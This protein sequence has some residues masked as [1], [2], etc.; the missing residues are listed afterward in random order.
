MILA[1]LNGREAAEIGAALADEFAPRAD[2]AGTRGSPQRGVS[3]SMEELLRRADV[4]VRPLQLNV[5]KKAKFANSFKW[6]LIENGVA[7]RTADE[8]TQS[9]VVH[10]SRGQIPVLNRNSADAAANRPDRAKAQHL[11]NRGNKFFEQGAHAEA[12]ALYEEAVALDASHAE[13]LNNLGS[14]LSYL[15]RYEEAEQWFRQAIAVKPNF[16]DPHCNLGILLR[17]KSHLS[18]SEAFLRRAL[19]LRPTDVDARINLGLTLVFLG[20]LR[21][22]RACFEKVLKSGPRNTLALYGMGQIETEEHTS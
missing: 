13:A 19:K 20:R 22:A 18:D 5:Y 14:A 10:L 21:D 12:A 8:V 7:R 15:G 3:G 2:S 11:F 16:S 1:W 6:R 9:L 17:Q 4:E